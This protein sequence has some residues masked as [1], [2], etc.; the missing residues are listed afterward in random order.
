MKPARRHHVPARQ[1]GVAMIEALIAFL[2]LSLGMLAL[3]RLQSD[4][5]INADAARER[6]AA[7]RLAQLDIER[8]RAFVDGAG[9]NAITDTELDVTPAG[10]TT[11]YTLTRVVVTNTEPALKS[12]QVTL[13]WND[14]HGAGQSLR[15]STL[16]A[17][18]DPVLAGALTLPHPPLA[19]P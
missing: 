10:D 2:V 1:R 4:L 13:R 15:L 12:V 7:M 9:W 19:H 14:R 16:I 3:A 17:G 6:T 5:R 18:H 8:L 11:A